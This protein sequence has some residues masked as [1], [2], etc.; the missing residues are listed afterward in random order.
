MSKTLRTHRRKMGRPLYTIYI[1]V[2]MHLYR[3]PNSFGPLKTYYS[4]NK[5]QLQV[6]RG[7]LLGGAICH[8]SQT[9]QFG[10]DEI[11]PHGVEISHR[12]YTDRPEFQKGLD[13]ESRVVVLGV[14]TW[15]WRFPLA[16]TRSSI[17][18]TGR[19]KL[20]GP[21]WT[22]DMHMGVGVVY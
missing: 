2:H 7:D 17:T 12:I 14:K 4:V 16:Q 9:A 5:G 22:C 10:E 8:G 3:S 19:D 11:G 15:T 20:I 6:E 1:Y 21:D 13:Y 18:P